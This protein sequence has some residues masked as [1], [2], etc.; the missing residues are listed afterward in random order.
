[1]TNPIP[2]RRVRARSR[3]ALVLPSKVRTWLYGVAIAFVP[4]AVYLGWMEPEAVPIVI[5]LI[6]A[7]LFVDRDGKPQS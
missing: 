1:M 7:V 5:P 2:S 3:L 6:L 4:L